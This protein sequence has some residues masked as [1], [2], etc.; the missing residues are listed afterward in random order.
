MYLKDDS[1]VRKYKSP[2]ES[3]IAKRFMTFSLEADNNVDGDD[4]KL[5]IRIYEF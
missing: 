1:T 2:T 4:L 3:G 5:C